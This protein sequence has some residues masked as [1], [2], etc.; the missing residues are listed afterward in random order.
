MKLLIDECLAHQVAALLA[1]AG[2]DVVHVADLG[3]A[4]RP[5]QEIMAAAVEL[6][7]AVVSADTDFG[8]LLARSAGGRPSVILMRRSGHR[9]EEQAAVLIANLPAVADDI[10]AGAIVVISND[11]V[12]VRPLPLLP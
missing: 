11:R 8:E 10:A 6:E 3:L 4:G 9:P 2:F 7:R 5:D 1:A 12:R